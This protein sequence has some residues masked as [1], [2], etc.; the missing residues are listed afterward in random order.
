MDSSHSPPHTL[1][2]L[3]QQRRGSSAGLSFLTNDGDVEHT[4]PYSALYDLARDYAQRLLAFGIQPQGSD[5][6]IAS[7]DNH[8]DHIL[9]FWACCFGE[10]FH[11]LSERHSLILASRYT[12]VSY[13]TSPPRAKPAHSIPQPPP[14]TLQQAHPYQQ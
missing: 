8:N 10:P 1:P 5:V 9:L 13:S 14:D 12:P 3:L 11:P 2:E 4:I 7:F 6:V